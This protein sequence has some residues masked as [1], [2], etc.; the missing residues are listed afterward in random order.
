MSG[1]VYRRCGCRTEAGRARGAACL[2]LAAG[3]KHGT[4]SFAVDLPSVDGARRTMRRGGFKTRRQASMALKAVTDRVQTSVRN[5]DK[6]TVGQYLTNWLRSQQHSLKPKSLH[7]YGQY[8]HKDL[9]PPCVS[10]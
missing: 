1:R 3:D 10:G 4:W 6:E 2:R 5:D 8:V 9:V 7:Q